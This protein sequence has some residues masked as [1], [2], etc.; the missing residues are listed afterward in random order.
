MRADALDAAIMPIASS[1]VTPSSPTRRA[2]AAI[3]WCHFGAFYS[4]RR[5][6]KIA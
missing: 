4:L 2:T 1:V 5:K 6:M 3:D